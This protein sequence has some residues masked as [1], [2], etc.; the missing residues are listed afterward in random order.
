MK[1]QKLYNYLSFLRFFR[2]EASNVEVNDLLVWL[3]SDKKNRQEYFNAKRA[4]LESA[5]D[6]EEQIDRSW[7]RLQYRL[8]RP[9]ENDYMIRA[10]R[11]TDW[12]IYA[13]VASVAVLLVFGIYSRFRIDSL[14][15]YGRN[16]NQVEAPFGSRA[17]IVLPDGTEV[18]LNSGSKLT[19]ALGYAARNREVMLN[20]EAFFD[21]KKHSRSAFIVHAK[22]LSIKALGTRFNIKSY[23]DE[24]TVEAFL[25]DGKIVIDK[26]N[27][28]DAFEPITLK[29]RQKLTYMENAEVAASV[30]KVQDIESQRS[31]TKSID[32]EEPTQ[33]MNIASVTYPDVD[34]SWKD[35]KLVIRSETLA[36]MSRKLERFYNIEIIF[37]N[38]EVRDY[39][40]S[41]TLDEVTIDEVMRAISSAAPISFSIE[42]NRVKLYSAK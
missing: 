24:R 6:Q 34:I 21:V 1:E 3:E 9:S 7:E 25:V 36:S 27:H 32:K 12:K 31:I 11:R 37:E 19:Y 20:G 14:E 23:P 10:N 26:K 13:L 5:G 18:W 40:F 39:V 4:W 22:D 28:D 38:E 33:Q 15:Q 2:G 29:P 42:K 41:G 16:V 35:E 30:H 17:N 8:F